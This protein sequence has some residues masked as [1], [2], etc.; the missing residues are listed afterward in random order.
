MRDARREHIHDRAPGREGVASGGGGEGAAGDGAHG[1]RSA[2]ERAAFAAFAA[3]RICAR[4]TFS[5][6]T[7]VSGSLAS[8]LAT[9][10]RM[11][12]PSSPTQAAAHSA[13]PG[14]LASLATAG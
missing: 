12:R 11:A 1:Q 4:V 13:K 5:G 8:A 9:I 7:A 2:A 14:A 6:Y 3:A 10:L